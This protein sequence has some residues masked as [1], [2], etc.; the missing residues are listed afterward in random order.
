MI[1]P[2][3]FLSDEDKTAIINH[4]TSSSKILLDKNDDWYFNDNT[5][6][7]NSHLKVLKNNGPVYLSHYLNGYIKQE[8]TSALKLGS[9]FHCLVLENKIFNDKYILFDD[10]EICLEIGGK[11][12]RATNR[13]KEYVEI[14]NSENTDKIIL[15]KNDWEQIHSMYNAV[16]EHSQSR[17]LLESAQ[18]REKIY[19]NTINGVPMKAKLDA[20]SANNYFIDLKSANFCPNQPNVI[21]EFYNRDYDM[22]AAIYS[23]ITEIEQ[24]WYIIVDKNN[25]FTVGI[26]EISPETIKKGREKYLSYLDYYK[27][28]LGNN[29]FDINS[30]VYMGII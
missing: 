20:V 17:Q 9:A 5:Y 15:N 11:M 10:T 14:F 28:T 12:P 21:K 16:M 1:T 25:P 4:K 23:D 30:F 24:V 26:Y 7:T 13:Y 27:N 29:N 2:S 3:N 19:T 6:V 22:Q 8:E 18:I